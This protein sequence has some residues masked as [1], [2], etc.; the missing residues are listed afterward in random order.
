[1]SP[2]T[3]P[4]LPDATPVLPPAGWPSQSGKSFRAIYVGGPTVILEIGGLRIMTD[5]TLDPAGG[6]YPIANTVYTKVFGPAIS[7]VGSIDV[8][9]LS[10]DQHHDN[11]DHKGREL[12]KNVNMTLTTKVGAA[13]LKGSSRGLAVWESVV[14]KAPNGDEILVTATPA[15]HGPVGFEALSGEVIGFVL[16]VSGSCSFEVYL[17]GDTVFYEGVN[18]VAQR[19]SPRYVFMYAGAGQPRGPFNVTMDTNDALGT[20]AAFPHATMIPLHYE[21]WSHYTQHAEAFRQ[22]FQALGIGNRLR[23]LAAGISETLPV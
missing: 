12:L 2:S 21:G 10:H 7:N 18:Q 6:V 13:R 19:F 16:S 14:L 11:L 8:V 9:L 5:P 20:A 23:I 1:M 3:I 17:T 22:A 4:Y 15:R